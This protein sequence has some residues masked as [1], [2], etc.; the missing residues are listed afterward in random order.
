MKM[1]PIDTKG[2]AIFERI[3]THD[4]VGVDVDLLKGVTRSGL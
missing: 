4:L 3:R 1:T 2:V